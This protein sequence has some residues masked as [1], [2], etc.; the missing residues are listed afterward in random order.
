MQSLQIVGEHGC[1]GPKNS[2]HGLNTKP[3]GSMLARI[4]PLWQ[5]VPGRLVLLCSMG[6]VDGL[7]IQI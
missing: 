1:M 2:W 7:G 4:I 3:R 5:V 6:H